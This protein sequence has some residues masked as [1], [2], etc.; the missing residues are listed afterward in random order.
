MSAVILEIKALINTISESKYINRI[1][2]RE[3]N[4]KDFDYDV[5]INNIEDKTRVLIKL[6]HTIYFNKSF[7][8]KAIK[9]IENGLSLLDIE[10]NTH[11]IVVRTE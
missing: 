8:I 1:D 5:I 2:I 11:R 9:G 3:L 6:E 4:A 7:N 10:G